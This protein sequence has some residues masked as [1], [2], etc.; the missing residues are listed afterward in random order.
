MCATCGKYG[1]TANECKSKK[2]IEKNKRYESYDNSSSQ[3]DSYKSSYRKGGN[4]DRG[5]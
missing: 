3:V 1:H 4:G 5:N 2:P